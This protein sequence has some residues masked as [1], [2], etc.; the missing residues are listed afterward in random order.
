MPDLLRVIQIDTFLRQYVSLEGKKMPHILS[1]PC[2]LL[3]H[4]LTGQSRQDE[5]VKER[6]ENATAL[7]VSNRR[8]EENCRDQS[9]LDEFLVI[10]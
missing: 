5:D 8:T 7:S 6:G 3:V 4:L 1:R 9:K 2:E 10:I